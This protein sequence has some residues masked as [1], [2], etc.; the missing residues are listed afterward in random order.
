MMKFFKAD[1]LKDKIKDVFKG[2]VLKES[3]KSVKLIRFKGTLDCR[4]TQSL[5]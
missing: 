4:S 3:I 5:S 2:D 1:L